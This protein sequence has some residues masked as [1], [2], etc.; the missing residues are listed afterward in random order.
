MVPMQTFNKRC[1]EANEL[2]VSLV[3]KFADHDQAECELRAAQANQTQAA[4]MS[5]QLSGAAEA[6]I[7][8]ATGANRMREELQQLRQDQE[9]KMEKLEQDLEQSQ[10]AHQVAMLI[11]CYSSCLHYQ[12]RASAAAIC[13][14]ACVLLACMLDLGITV[15]GLAMSQ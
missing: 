12:G 10:L 4:G 13:R 8:A 15:T 11:I 3:V 1:K 14:L 5:R 2:R 7:L 6:D 9:R